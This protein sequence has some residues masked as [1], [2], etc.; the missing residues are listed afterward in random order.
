MPTTPGRND[1]EWTKLC[2]RLKGELEPICWICGEYIDRRLPG[3]HK[4]GWTLDHVRSLKDYPELAHDPKNLK[5]AHNIHNVQR[6][7][8]GP[9]QVKFSR[10]M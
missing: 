9:G 4:M 10:R 7:T 6:G 2:K 8:G 1:A 3:T 5:P